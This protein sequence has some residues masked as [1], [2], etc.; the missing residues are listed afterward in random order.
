MQIRKITTAG[1]S[2][3]VTLPVDALRYLGLK[4]GD[5]VRIYQE[6]DCIRIM[7][8]E[9]TPE[10]KARLADKESEGKE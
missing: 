1:N 10:I 5:N 7:P 9:V 2:L 4:R 3:A 6:I 8:V